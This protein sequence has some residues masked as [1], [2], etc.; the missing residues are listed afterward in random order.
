MIRTLFVVWTL[1]CE[2]TVAVHAADARQSYAVHCASCHG[3]TG[4]G[5][6][7]GPSLIGVSAPYI[8]FMLDTG[9]M[10][11]EVPNVEQTHKASIF[12]ELQIDDLTKYVVSFS[13][14]TKSTLPEVG[15]GDIGR[16]RQLFAENC[17][18]CHGAGG[19]GGAV[20]YGYNRVA[21]SLARATVFQVAEA[22]RAGPGVMPKFG[23]DV[24]SDQDV[25][26]LARYVSFL[27]TGNANPGGMALSNIG[28][29]AEGFVAWV[30]GFGMLIA[31]I[32]RLGTNA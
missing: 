28:P 26:D 1:L 16:G 29:V 31:L 4:K 18:H 21:P 17:E 2:S 12:S 24:L 8:H 32:R 11:A 13:G 15:P 25:D 20:G 19:E 3:S 5:S 22:V 27:Q 6:A 10:P 30:F 23:E 7:L 14:S 9:R